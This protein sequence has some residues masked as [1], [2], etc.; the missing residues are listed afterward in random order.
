VSLFF[1]SSSS[2]IADTSFSSL[3][4]AKRSRARRPGRSCSPSATSRPNRTARRRLRRLLSVEKTWDLLRG[5]RRNPYEAAFSR[6]C[7]TIIHDLDD[8]SRCPP[9]GILGDEPTK[10][11]QLAC[12]A[13]GDDGEQSGVT[14]NDANYRGCERP[15]DREKGRGEGR[16]R[17]RRPRKG[18]GG[19]GREPGLPGP[20]SPP[21]LPLRA[22]W[23]TLYTA[24]RERS[25]RAGDDEQGEWGTS[26]RKGCPEGKE[27]G[28]PQRRWVYR[29]AVEQTCGQAG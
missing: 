3:L 27:K 23:T 16:G 17:S 9:E 11:K 20:T 7:T 13:N 10:T 26:Q 8:P 24:E 5:H 2:W 22:A 15:R 12:D 28:G 18:G 14:F 19:I 29:K 21:H 25:F 1:F 4:P 6:S